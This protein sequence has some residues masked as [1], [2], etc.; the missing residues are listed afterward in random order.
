[1]CAEWSGRG[2]VYIGRGGRTMDRVQ[3]DGL[4]VQG[5]AIGQR[6]GGGACPTRARV[7]GAPP[8]AGTAGRATEG[9]CTE[10]AR[11]YATP[12]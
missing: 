4:R 3:R 8:S 5:F 2:A 1:V 9:H 6:G 11:R 12:S 7:F 10:S